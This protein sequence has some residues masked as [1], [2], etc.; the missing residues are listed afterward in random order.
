MRVVFTDPVNMTHYY[1]LSFVNGVGKRCRLFFFTSEFS[2]ELLRYPKHVNTRFLFLRAGSY[3]NGK[4]NS[5]AL[6]R[7]IR[8]A[9]YPFS[10]L[11]LLYALQ[12]VKPD[13]VHINWSVLPEVDL[14]AIKM[15]RSMGF[16]VLY[17]AHN[18]VPH[19]GIGNR[20][21]CYK[22]IMHNVDHIVCLTQHVKEE[23]LK[24]FHLA[25]NKV[26]V[27][28]HGDFDFVIEQVE[29]TVSSKKAKCGLMPTCDFV[30]SFFGLIRPYKGL[31]YLLKALPAIV[32]R[33]PGCMLLVFGSAST[34]DADYYRAIIKELGL[35][36]SVISDFHYVPLKEVVAYLKVTDIAVLPYVSA[37]QSGNIPM[38]SKMGIPVVATR[39]GGLPEMIREGTNGMLVPP[40]SPEAISDAVCSLLSNPERLKKMKMDSIRYAAEAFSWDKIAADMMKV[41]E[42]VIDSHSRKH[43][44][45]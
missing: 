22:T 39:V 42:K 8:G 24:T 11:A 12:T 29:D 15:M 10:Y 31:E 30:I 35:S 20:Y 34:K 37:S 21:H 26:S 32:R 14:L 6:R 38:L 13:I 27:V 7:L 33:I 40:R 45:H 25:R 3:I 28:R 4:T 17:T 44:V 5:R 19:E 9:E 43:I 18:A 41:Y 2:Y 1:N 36:K 23:I 16:P